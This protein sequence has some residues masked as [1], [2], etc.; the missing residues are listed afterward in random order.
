M[1]LS[2]W[3]LLVLLTVASLATLWLPLWGK[4]KSTAI[5]AGSVVMVLLSVGLY[6]SIGSWQQPEQADHEGMSPEA[7]VSSLARRLQQSGGTVDEYMMLG[8]SYVQMKRLGDAAQAYGKAMEVSD[9]KNP[10]VMLAFAETKAMME[11]LEGE[12]GALIEQ[13]LN[14]APTNPRALWYGG[15]VAREKGDFDTALLRWEKL[16]AMAPQDVK[17][18]I[19]PGIEE[20]KRLK[21]DGPGAPPMA[22]TTPQESGGKGVN[23]TVTAPESLTQALNPGTVVFVVARSKSGGPPLAVVQKTL[24]D[25]PL[26]VSLTD[27]NAMMPGNVISNHEEVTLSARLALRGTAIRQSGD[28]IAETSAKLGSDVEL[29]ISDVVP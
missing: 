11:G 26:S 15:I 18:A 28:L 14:L 2:F 21:R 29:T 8:R 16:S 9:G 4:G 7:M 25:L 13:A 3:I 19:A 6:L 1:D 10:E 23:V 17:D 12:A 24:K 20:L 5:A 27:D 22:S